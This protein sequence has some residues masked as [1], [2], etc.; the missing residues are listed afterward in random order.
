M[1]S[2]DPA[3]VS[4]MTAFTSCLPKGWATPDAVVD[5]C[6]DLVTNTCTFIPCLVTYTKGDSSA[7]TDGEIPVETL[8]TPTPKN[9]KE[10]APDSTLANA[11]AYDGNAIAHF[12]SAETDCHKVVAGG[13]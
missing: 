10:N 2:A 8:K 4:D 5:V 11:M 6:P 1:K 3:F 13:E 9:K 12:P 7:S